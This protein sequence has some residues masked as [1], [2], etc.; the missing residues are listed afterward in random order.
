MHNFDFDEEDIAVFKDC[1]YN[2]KINCP[3][4]ELSKYF[5]IIDKIV[6]SLAELREEQA[7]ERVQ[8]KL[9]GKYEK[10]IQIHKIRIE[11][12]LSL[13]KVATGRKSKINDDT[14][15]FINRAITEK[16][17]ESKAAFLREV[18]EKYA[19][20]KETKEAERVK[21]EEDRLKKKE[22]EKQ[23]SVKKK[24]SYSSEVQSKEGSNDSA[25]DSKEK[26]A[27]KMKKE[28]AIKIKKQIK[29]KSIN[30]D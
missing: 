12:D 29:E 24:K 5:V 6:S 2:I 1:I 23:K 27:S 19:A 22:M 26:E 30:L 20:Y 14:L 28:K 7:K 11:K 10:R 13:S 15:R 9:E 8:R 4:I 18:N 3:G 25:E 16:K 17:G 21:E